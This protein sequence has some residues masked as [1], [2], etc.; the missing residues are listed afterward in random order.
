MLA[1][2][3]NGNLDTTTGME[4]MK[5]MTDLN[6]QG[7]TIIIVTHEPGIANYCSH[8]IHLRDGKV[9]FD[10]TPGEAVHA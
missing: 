2:E 7:V 5:L 1:D 10:G 9:I 4:I 8:Q 6:E 3:P